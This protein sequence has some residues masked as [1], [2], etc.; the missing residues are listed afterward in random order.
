MSVCVFDD[1]KRALNDTVNNCKPELTNYAEK[2]LK[3]IIKVKKTFFKAFD[4]FSSL[5]EELKEQNILLRDLLKKA[6]ESIWDKLEYYVQLALNPED[7][8]FNSLKNY[9]LDMI[10]SCLQLG[11]YIKDEESKKAYDELSNI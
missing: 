2:A 1:V 3:A 10:L 9:P 4:E 11:Y 6:V 8:D 7:H 5:E